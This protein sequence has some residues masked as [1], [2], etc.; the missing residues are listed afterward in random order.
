MNLHDY[1][2]SIEIRRRRRVHMVI[3]WS[4]YFLM[5]GGLLA[6]SIVMSMQPR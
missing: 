3:S 1:E 5:L 4:L 6:A 2:A